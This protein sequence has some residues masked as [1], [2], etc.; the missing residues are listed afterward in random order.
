MASKPTSKPTRFA[1]LVS[2][3]RMAPAP[4]NTRNAHSETLLV[5]GAKPQRTFA[6]AAG[7]SAYVLQAGGRHGARR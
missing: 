4:Q 2:I 5:K 6:T 3:N 7:A 1:H